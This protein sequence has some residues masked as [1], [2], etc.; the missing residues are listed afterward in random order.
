MSIR[1]THLETFYE[2]DIS[3]FFPGSVGSFLAK[4]KTPVAISSLV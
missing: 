3:H 1:Y 2:D 4:D